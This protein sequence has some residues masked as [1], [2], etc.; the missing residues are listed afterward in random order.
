M[1]AIH[2]WCR[3]ERHR[4]VALNASRFGQPLYE[5]HGLCRD[6]QPDDVFCV[7]IAARYNPTILAARP[8]EGAGHVKTP[9]HVQTET[10][11]HA[12]HHH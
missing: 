7:G 4:L 1:E 11:E 2:A 10:R 6:A 9:I 12:L 8:P 5:S 3:E